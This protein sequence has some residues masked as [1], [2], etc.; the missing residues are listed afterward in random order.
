[1]WTEARNALLLGRLRSGMADRT[2]IAM[3][4]RDALD[5]ATR[6][7]ASCLG[8]DGEIGQLSVGACADIAV[9]PLD[10]MSF[11]GAL[12][13]P[14]EA[15]VR[16]GPASPSHTIINGEVVVDGGQLVADGSEDILRQHRRAAE[17][18]QAD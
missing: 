14:I 16:C 11:A 3:R 18:M 10:G 7:G 15:W 4:A 17:S 6:G 9:W 1:M 12:S 8:R 2:P 5:M 13:D